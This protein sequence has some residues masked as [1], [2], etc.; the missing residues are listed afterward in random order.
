M[1]YV[2]GGHLNDGYGHLFEGSWYPLVFSGEG[3]ARLAI[4]GL[5]GR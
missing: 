3:E 5:S 4:W 2:H 1:R